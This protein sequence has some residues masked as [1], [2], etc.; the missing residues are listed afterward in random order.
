MTIIN[1]NSIS[2]I[3]SIT[4][5][6]S[7]AAINLFKA[8]GTSANII[9]GVV[10][11]TSLDISGDIDVDGHTELD[12]VK[13]SG[14]ASVHNTLRFTHTGGG[15]IDHGAVDHNLNFRVSKSSTA[16]TTMMQINASSENTKFRKYVT[17]GLQGGDDTAVLGGGSGIGAYLQLN[18]ASNSIVNTKLLGNGNSWLNSNYGNLG[19]GTAVAGKK[20]HVFGSNSHPVIL[21]RGDNANTQIELKTAA[22]TRG[23]WGASDTA[24][25]MVY[26]NDASDVNFTVLQTGQIGIGNIVPDTWSTGHGLTIGTSQATLWGVGDQVNLSGNAYFNSGWKAAATKAGAS[27]IQ[28]ALGN[29][30][31]RVTGSINADAAITWTEAVRITPAGVIGI[32]DTNPGTGKKVKV[33]VA[34]NSSYQMAVNLTNNVNADIN[35]YIKTSESLIAP[36]TN[37]PLLLGT[38]GGEKLRIDSAG[39][40]IVGGGTHAGGSAL[41]VK[42]G[43]QNSYSTVGMFS[44]HTNPAHDTLLSQIRFGSNATAVGADIRV[45]SVTDWASNDYPTRMSFYTTPDGSNSRQERLRISS[46]GHITAPNNVAFSARGGPAD[47]TNDV[48]IFATQ[49]FQRGGTNYSTSTGIFTAPVAGIY[50]FMCNPYRYTDSN[51][52]ALLLE[53]S[54][55]GG[56]SWSTQIEIRNMNDYLS[57]SGR[58]WFTLSLSQLIDLNKDDQVRVK[59]VSRI[60]CNGVYSRFSGFLVA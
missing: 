28:Q 21:E 51:D 13:I 39:R 44:N 17:V 1:P 18:Y 48:I 49:V 46:D 10:T 6:N 27:Q 15:H 56:S 43:N 38:G 32:N 55:N 23:Y 52:S 9:A 42:G 40:C 29:I 36:S 19:I 35:F 14:I 16:D 41:V 37:T 20:L 7:T 8:D 54:T 3:S 26:D 57:D 34:D 5:L 24:N 45:Y 25:F 50:H 53:T 12:N 31:F 33:V 2:G 11:A 47:L 60:H 30:D 58:G 22:A 4:A 59:A